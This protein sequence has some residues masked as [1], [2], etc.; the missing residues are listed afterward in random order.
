MTDV[1]AGDLNAVGRWAGNH[2]GLASSSIVITI[3]ITYTLRVSGYDPRIARAMVAATPAETVTGALVATLPSI[4]AILLAAFVVR[5]SLTTCVSR[6]KKLAWLVASVGVAGLVAPILVFAAS[7]CISFG[8]GLLRRER[9]HSRDNTSSDIGHSIYNVLGKSSTGSLTKGLSLIV[10]GSTI[11]IAF[12][13]PPG[14]PAEILYFYERSD[15]FLAS[16][17]TDGHEVRDSA[18]MVARVID[19]QGDWWP[20]IDVSTWQLTMIRGEYV[21]SR[22]MCDRGGEAWLYRRLSD[23]WD[24]GYPPC[25]TS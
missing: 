13:G 18:P 23:L 6:K 3:S 16:F 4:F 21:K 14:P 12:V 25:P 8:L 17:N 15:E 20:A 22:R 9:E 1:L 24:E 2:P 5:A 11:I 19:D 7:F 10:L